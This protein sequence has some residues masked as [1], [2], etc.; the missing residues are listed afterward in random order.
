M[1]YIDPAGN[2]GKSF[3]VRYWCSHYP[4]DSVVFIRGAQKQM[5]YNYDGQKYI[6]L[7]WLALMPSFAKNLEQ[8]SVHLN[9]RVLINSTFHKQVILKKL[10]LK[11]P[12]MHLLALYSHHF[13]L[14]SLSLP[15]VD[16]RDWETDRKSVV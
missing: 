5:F 7:I 14:V 12:Y 4:D 16:Y 15:F 13:L 8:L 10:S 6:F 11:N 1:F 3:F 2:S 9:F